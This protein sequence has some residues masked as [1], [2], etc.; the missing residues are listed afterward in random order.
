MVKVNS[1][2]SRDKRVVMDAATLDPN[3]PQDMIYLN[4][5]NEAL[6]RGD[7]EEA[8]TILQIAENVTLRDSGRY[9]EAQAQQNTGNAKSLAAEIV[10]A[11][12]TAGVFKEDK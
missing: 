11:L 7:A 4:M 9:L 10:T 1:R 12:T 5:H 6:A 2:Y 3:C 8:I